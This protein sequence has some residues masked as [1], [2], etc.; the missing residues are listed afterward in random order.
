MTETAGIRLGYGAEQLPGGRTDLTLGLDGSLVVERTAGARRDTSRGRVDLAVLTRV[1]TSLRSAPSG[2]DAGAAPEARRL[3][4]SGLS[5][6]PASWADGTTTPVPPV[7]DA[8]QALAEQVLDPAAPARLAAGLFAVDERTTTGPDTRQAAAL[9]TVR[10]RTAYA[11]AEPGQGFGLAA[12]D[13]QEPLGGSGDEPGLRPSAL[14]L[15]TAGERELFAVGSEDGSVQVWDAAGG[16][17]LHGTSGGEGTQQVAAAV[18]QGIPLVFSVGTQGEVRAWR[19]E[20]GRSLGLL[21]VGE[22]GAAALCYAHCAGLDLV[23]AGGDD[24]VVRVWDVASGEQLH[25]LVGHGARVT[26]LAILSLGEQAVLASAG[27]DQTVRLWDLATGQPV[28]E[29]TGHSGSVTGLAFLEADGRPVLASCALDGTV[30]TWDVYTGTAIH[31]W[32][33]GGG[34]P[35]ALA[36]TVLDG[37][38]VIVTGDE[39]GAVSLWRPNGSA[40]STG[41]GTGAPVNALAVGESVLAVGYGDGSVQLFGPDLRT[42]GYRVEPEGGPVS[43]LALTTDLLVCGTAAG[44]VRGHRLSDGAQLTVPTPHTGP[45]SCLAFHDGGTPV[46]ASGGE[47]GTVRVRDAVGGAPLLHLAAHRE[48]V[49]A[50]AVGSAD[51]HRLL[52]TAGRDGTVRLWHGG[53]G[54]AGPVLATLARPAEVLAFDELGGRPVVIGGSADGEV[55]VW[56]VREGRQVGALTGG[57]PAVRALACQNLDGEVLLAA[58]DAAATLRLWH[59]ASGSLLNEAVLDRVP[60]AIA[61]GDSGLHVVGP[62]GATQL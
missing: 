17:L 15:G 59:L 18:V 20:D 1:L 51:G 38:P 34:W 50:L 9:G 2:S 47:D 21:S 39:N 16:A 11:L 37:A 25:L 49:T 22:Q 41:T 14:A 19:A 29:L 23:A 56:D 26:A 48:G 36:A 3:T 57:G 60:L 62:G 6:G 40:L 7:A 12:L 8:L 28:A 58:G 32:P 46:L 54:Q 43:S 33:A 13:D 61:F 52:A 55:R 5:A 44:S 24:A 53:S 10:G 42:P 31:G 35:T 30:R 4:V 45:V 27:L